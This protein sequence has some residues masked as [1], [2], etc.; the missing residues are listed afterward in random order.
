MIRNRPAVEQLTYTAPLTNRESEEDYS[1]Q[2]K[3]PVVKKYKLRKW[4]LFL[5][6]VFFIT[7]SV[8]AFYF[9]KEYRRLA[10]NP[11]E[12]TNK[13]ISQLVT[14]LG[15]LILLPVGEEPALFTVEDKEKLKSQGPFFE[16][17]EN[18]D[19]VLVFKKAKK[20]ILY[21]PSKNIIIEVAP[22]P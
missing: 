20:V 2:P 7:P 6:I 5:V 11:E 8:L 4:R 19:K 18:E 12:E 3:K 13:E 14:A 17:V 21:R 10:K 22:L 16:K 9:F 1:E 15:K